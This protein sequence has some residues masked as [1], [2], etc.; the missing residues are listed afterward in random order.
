MWCV[1][2]EAVSCALF[3]VSR[4]Y[5]S[6]RLRPIA[7]IR[8]AGKPRMGV[9]ASH[10]SHSSGA[11]AALRGERNHLCIEQMHHILRGK[12]TLEPESLGSGT[13]ELPHKP[14]KLLAFDM[15]GDR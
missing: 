11:G 15:L 1:A 13:A 2:V 4:R 12:R 14:E 5:R 6:C 9:C 7:D 10:S 8:V 3:S